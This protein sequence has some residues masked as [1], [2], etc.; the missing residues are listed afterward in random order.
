MLLYWASARPS[1][2]HQPCQSALWYTRV[3][4]ETPSP[5]EATQPLK[6]REGS[7][8]SAAFSK[9]RTRARKNC[10][11][12]LVACSQFSLPRVTTGVRWDL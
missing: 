8:R 7:A 9:L 11:H 10:E 4:G 1:P 12:A 6:T 3:G 5:L 2:I